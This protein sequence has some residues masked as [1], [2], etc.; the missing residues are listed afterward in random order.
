MKKI[1]LIST[2]LL[3]ATICFGQTEDT[4]TKPAKTLIVEGWDIN[5]LDIKY[6]EIV[7]YYTYAYGKS[8]AIRFDIGKIYNPYKG[9]KYINE[10]GES[11]DF[12]SPMDALNYITEC[13]WE[14]VSN[15]GG[16][17]GKV[18]SLFYLMRKK[19]ILNN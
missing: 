10:N 6:I 18:T 16:S 12:N 2:I 13:G 5:K 4:I 9:K 17:D 15:N 3:T 19:K 8:W 14:F 7:C 11:I 1:L